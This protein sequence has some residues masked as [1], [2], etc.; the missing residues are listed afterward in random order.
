MEDL[1]PRSGQL[2]TVDDPPTVV[3]PAVRAARRRRRWSRRL[4]ITVVVVLAVL[5]LGATVLLAVSPGVTDAQR[6]VAALDAAHGVGTLTTPVPARFA[7]A[8]TAT[9]D[10]RFYAD[11][12]VDPQSVLRVLWA[13]P[14]GDGADAGGATLDQQLAKQLYGDGASGSVATVAEQMALAVKLDAS[15]SKAQILEM[16]AS[17]V[18]FGNGY[19]GLTAASQG[20]FGVP[21]DRLSWGQTAMLAGLVQA[22]SADDP[23]RHLSV[24][25]ARQRHVLGRLVATGQLSRS[26]ADAAAAAPLHLV[27]HD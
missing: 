25:L 21:P 3:I 26:A 9:E 27:A 22:P 14:H 24:A 16:Y 2:I 1:S 4:L 13:L 15:Y 23:V 10:S 20:Y 6:R 17:V 8:L 18:Y 19:Y 7:A 11:H 12:G 5:G